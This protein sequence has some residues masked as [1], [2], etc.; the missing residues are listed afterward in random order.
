MLVTKQTR[1]PRNR[2]A[3]RWQTKAGTIGDMT[4]TYFTA[5]APPS[6]AEAVWNVVCVRVSAQ[7]Q[8]EQGPHKPEL[9]LHPNS[10]HRSATTMSP[11]TYRNTAACEGSMR[12]CPGLADI[13]SAQHDFNTLPVQLPPRAKT[14]EDVWNVLRLC[15]SPRGRTRN[16]ENKTRKPQKRHPPR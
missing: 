3:S 10:H 5:A 7:G 4:L 9:D 12:S 1:N 14:E 6:K 16:R 2:H 15:V 8:R 11:M 13:H